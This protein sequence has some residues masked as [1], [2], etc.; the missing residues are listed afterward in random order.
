MVEE[1]LLPT[2]LESLG[3]RCTLR[4]QK[5]RFDSDKG[6]KHYYHVLSFFQQIHIDFLSVFRVSATHSQFLGGL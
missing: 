3:V 4:K 2:W 6:G 1:Q 5:S